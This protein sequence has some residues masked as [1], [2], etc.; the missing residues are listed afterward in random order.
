[1]NEP[2]AK[3]LVVDDEPDNRFIIEEYLEDLGHD[4]IMAGDG[5]EAWD[6]LQEQANSFDTILLDIMMP[7]MN[8]LELLA[9]I[10]ASEQLRSIPVILQTAKGGSDDIAAG[11]QAGAFYYLTKPFSNEILLSIVE[12]AIRDSRRYRSLEEEALKGASMFGM[13]KS[14]IFQFRSLDEG[15]IVLH[16]LAQACPEPSKA[17]LGLSELLINA[18]EHGNLEIDYQ[19]KSTLLENG[20][21]DDEIKRRLADD[22]F[23]NRYVEVEYE[24]TSDSLIFTITDQ[25][26]GFDWQ[27]FMQID[28]A[29]GSD[30]HGR[31]IA[32]ANMISFDRIEYHGK[33]NQ[34]RAVFNL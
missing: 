20:T 29:R 26:S 11:I 32:M 15:Q 6:I 24:R 22:K 8:G 13:M 34:V 12:T 21:W 33:G 23:A 3:I 4:L 17:I 28:A 19:L 7:R 9:K 27:P 31:G 16:T 2:R 1:M 30:N 25:G 18:V 14:G 5:V 10:K